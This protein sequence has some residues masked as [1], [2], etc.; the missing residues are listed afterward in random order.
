MENVCTTFEGLGYDRIVAALLERWGI[1]GTPAEGNRNTILYRLARE[2]RYITDFSAA[3]LLAVIPAWG[4][5]EEEGGTPWQVPLQAPE[6]R[7]CR[8]M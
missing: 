6:A 7:S 3:K 1:Y 2:L 5:G 8:P 4:L